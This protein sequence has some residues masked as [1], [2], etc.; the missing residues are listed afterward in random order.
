M[1]FL[2]LTSVSKRYGAVTAVNNLDLAILPGSRT[3]VVGPSGSG[4][5]TLLRLIAGFEAPD[6]GSI[7]MDNT[8]LADAQTFTPAHRRGI[9]DLMEQVLAGLEPA[10]DEADETAEREIRVCVIGRPNVG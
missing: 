9:G 2:Q 5:T 6:A 10:A 1:S 7:A 8:I 3:V 4:K